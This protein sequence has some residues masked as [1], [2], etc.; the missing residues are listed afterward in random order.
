[1]WIGVFTPGGP[2]ALLMRKRYSGAKIEG[3]GPIS[4]TLVPPGDD[5]PREASVK[6]QDL[7]STSAASAVGLAAAC[8]AARLGNVSMRQ[9]RGPA[10]RCE[11]FFS[12]TGLT[13]N[14]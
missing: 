6:S 4:A 7:P 13:S 8:A 12:A 3:T 10:G 9:Y 1:M 11:T 2:P 5:P 14:F